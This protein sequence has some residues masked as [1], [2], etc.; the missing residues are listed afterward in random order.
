M[1][2]LLFVTALLAGCYKPD[3]Q[4]RGFACLPQQANGCPEG[5]TCIAGRCDNGSG[6]FDLASAQS[7]TADLLT[8]VGADLTFE[9]V[10]LSMPG[11]STPDLSTPSAPPD[12]ATSCAQLND[13]CVHSA[14]CCSGH[15]HL[16][17][18]HV[19]F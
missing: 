17:T 18:T 2:R 7:E 6:V 5:F 9:A 1:A 4:N 3:I 13:A 14:D 11:T 12:M 10:D 16:Y 15:C 19:C 8:P